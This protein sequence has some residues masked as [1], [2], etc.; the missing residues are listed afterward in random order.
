MNKSVK[1][2]MNQAA[3]KDT[4]KMVK[5]KPPFASASGTARNTTDY[6]TKARRAALKIGPRAATG[7]RASLSGPAAVAMTVGPYIAGRA[8]KEMAMSKVNSKPGRGGQMKRKT[9]KR[10]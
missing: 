1:K 6:G 10:Y 9:N 5:K 8:A 3:D 2:V 7:L 4:R